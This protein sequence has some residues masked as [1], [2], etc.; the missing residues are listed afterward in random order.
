MAS[1]GRPGQGEAAEYYSKY[2]DRVPGD[3]VLAVLIRQRD[4]T[5]ARL[6]Q[7]TE[8]R[9]QHRY[10]AG[11]WSLREMLNH[12]NDG[13][14]VF[15]VRAL[16]FAREYG[17]E[18]PGFDQDEGP[19]LAGAHAVP[20]AEHVAEFQALRSATIALFQHLPAEAWS[21]TGIASGNPVS[22]RAIAYILAGHVMHHEAML[23]ERYS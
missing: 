20:W 1:V 3:D 12:V 23:A 22:V 15:A 18:L 17:P 21:R 4:E 2:I 10:E 9:S 13:E 19:R 8:E 14:R 16:W 5:V 11:K 7:I 6:K